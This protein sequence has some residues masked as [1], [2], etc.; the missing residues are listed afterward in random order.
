MSMSQ[1]EY[2]ERSQE[3]MDY[4]Y[5]GRKFKMAGVTVNMMSVDNRCAVTPDQ[6]APITSDQLPIIQCIYST[7]FGTL[8]ELS[9]EWPDLEALE[10]MNNETPLEKPPTVEYVDRG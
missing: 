4:F 2:D 8:M 3:I 9:V 1:E 5:P 6:V 10:V 7:Y